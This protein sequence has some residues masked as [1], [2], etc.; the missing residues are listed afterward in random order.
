MNSR[1]LTEM[2]READTAAKMAFVI[3]EAL[4]EL[5]RFEEGKLADRVTE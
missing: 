3:A 2:L 1:E 5:V 4:I